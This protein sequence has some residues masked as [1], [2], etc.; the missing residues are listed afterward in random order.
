MIK[1]QVQSF[2]VLTGSI[3]FLTCL[4]LSATFSLVLHGNC[5]T[6]IAAKRRQMG[7]I[8]V[9]LLLAILLGQQADAAYLQRPV[10]K[11]SA[12]AFAW[13]SVPVLRTG[14]SDEASRVIYEVS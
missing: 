14:V 8:F 13:G 3:A 5:L 6:V 9:P 2:L 7:L 10:A 1:A 11:S 12:P 4:A